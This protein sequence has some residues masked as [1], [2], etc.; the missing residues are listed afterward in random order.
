MCSFI[1]SR[2]N[3]K[4]PAMRPLRVFQQTPRLAKARRVISSLFPGLVSYRES[5]ILRFWSVVTMERII[6]T[7]LAG[8]VC[9]FSGAGG[10]TDLGKLATAD[11]VIILVLV[12]PL[13]ETV[14][15]QALPCGLA[16]LCSWGFSIQLIVSWVP[17]ALVHLPSGLST[18]ISAGL[19]SGYYLAQ[20]YVRL[21]RRSLLIAFVLTVASHAL[22][23]LFV[24]L[25]LV[26]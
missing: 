23:N 25:I 19:V 11:L 17:F 4:S 1:A 26:W 7:I 5:S 9:V 18:F 21:R 20:T 16:R 6:V 12:A 15:F 3:P 2:S 24:A 22:L 13:L 10:R 8:V 14:V